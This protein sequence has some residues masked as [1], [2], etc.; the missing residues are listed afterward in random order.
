MCLW[1]CADTKQNKTNR[2][3]VSC[4]SCYDIIEVPVTCLLLMETQAVPMAPIV[5]GRCYLTVISQLLV[6]SALFLHLVVKLETA[7]VYLLVSFLSSVF[8]LMCFTRT[9]Q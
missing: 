1:S 5:P 7:L 4:F 3:T 9:V 6:V 8:C 2:I